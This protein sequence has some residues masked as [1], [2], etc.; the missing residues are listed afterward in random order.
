MQIKADVLRLVLSQV[1]E[2]SLLKTLFVLDA[3]LI[4]ILNANDSD[5]K[6]Q[7]L[8]R[9]A[10]KQFTKHNIKATMCQYQLREI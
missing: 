8:N 5:I 6:L 4:E 7:D 10:M 2:G 1:Y 9:T 3:F